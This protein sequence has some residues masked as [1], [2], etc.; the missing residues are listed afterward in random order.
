M[1]QT[2]FRNWLIPVGSIA[3]LAVM[4]AFI[5]GVSGCASS[6]RNRYFGKTQAPKDN[7]LRYVAGAE[8]ESLDPQ[9]SNGQPE[10]R[11]DMALYDGLVE[12]HPK[13][14]AP[15]PAIAKNWEI[16]SNVD[17]FVFHLR[18]NAKWSDG[19]PI[20]SRDFLYSFRRGFAPKT[21]SRSVSLGYFIK[22]AAAY[23]GNEVFVKKNG[24]FLL[25]KDLEETA[26]EQAVPAPSLGAETEFHKFIRSPDRLTLSGD[27]KRRAEQIEADPKLQAALAGDAEFVP[28]TAEDIGVE[29]IDDYTLRINLRQPAPFFL[30]L[31]GH[32]FFRLVPQQAIEKYGRSWTRPENII[33][34]GAFK[35]KEIRP[36]DVYIFE[37][38]PNYWDAA[39]VHLNGIEFYPIEEQSTSLN[40][41]KAGSIDAF[42]NHTVPSSWVDEVRQYNDEYLNFPENATSYYS[43]NVTRA[44]FNDPKIRQAFSLAIDREKLS[45]FR[46]VTKPLYFQTPSGIF[47]DY[48]AAME[49]VGEEIRKQR[50][51]SPDEWEK[52][53]KQF[54]PEYSRKL[55]SDAGYP[56]KQNGKSFTCP[57]FP[58]D[59]ISLTYNSNEANRAIAEFI[60]A[61]WKQNLGIVVP[62]SNMEFKTYLPFRN[63][64]Q[65]NGF[66]VTLW[67]GDYMDPYTFLNL[68]YGQKNDGGAGF[69]DPEYDRMLD[70]ANSELDP[71]KRYEKLARAEYYLL[72]QRPVIPLMINATNWMKKPFV[73][74]MYPNSGTLHAWK[75]VYIE[76][77]PAKWD[78]DV[79]NIMRDKDPLFEEQLKNLESTQIRTGSKN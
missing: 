66:A 4:L 52:N 47:P 8:P 51:I 3:S 16:S 32:Q 58:A 56:V 29:A 38:D 36:Y 6:A 13:T 31:L 22:Y 5:F 18:D 54:N 57:A 71:Q 7:I 40:L 67:S 28:V 77:D 14:M 23:N 10:A 43:I 1:K 63:S 34:C 79:E 26:S 24:N 17:E 72:E 35:V 61:E 65:Y 49:K 68:H 2:S 64:L 15:I 46:K 48:D 76:T 25:I 62:L 19:T 44:P 78:T 12:Y 33:T 20:T 42:F 73:K 45:S 21:L 37:R 55:L 9:L 53:R 69:Y 60:Q 75:F 11:L 41:Y 70:T 74:G 50:N 39:N 27:E 59:S 30:G